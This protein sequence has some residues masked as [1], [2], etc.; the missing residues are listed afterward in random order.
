MLVPERVV[1]VHVVIN[2]RIQH[3]KQE[4]GKARYPLLTSQ[5]GKRAR[6][7]KLMWKRRGGE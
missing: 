6:E 3:P 7:R 2:L 4:V 1:V 5:Y